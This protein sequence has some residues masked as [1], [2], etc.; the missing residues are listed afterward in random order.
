MIE[1]WK[2]DRL[3]IDNCTVKHGGA[4]GLYLPTY[5]LLWAISIPLHLYHEHPN[6]E[7]YVIV[8]TYVFIAR[9][10]NL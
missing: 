5:L 2:A 4:S 7:G 3:S 6:L 1:A 8:F 9:C 10:M